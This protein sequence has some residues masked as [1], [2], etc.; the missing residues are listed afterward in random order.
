MFLNFIQT[1]TNFKF[2]ESIQ[3]LKETF[4][5]KSDPLSR[6]NVTPNLIVNK[7]VQPKMNCIPTKAV[8]QKVSF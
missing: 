2:F 3:A 7:A 6:K 5:Y 4:S 1:Y 8:A